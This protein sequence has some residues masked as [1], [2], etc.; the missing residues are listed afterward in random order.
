VRALARLCGVPGEIVD[1]VPSGNVFDGRSDEEMLGASYDEIE[2]FLRLREVH[3]ADLAAT[4]SCAAALARQHAHNQHKYRVGLPS[5]TV[6]V[7]PRGVPG[8]SSDEVWTPRHERRPPA[9]TLPGQWE[10][11]PAL[12]AALRTRDEMGLTGLT[13]SARSA[14]FAAFPASSPLSG[15]PAFAPLSEAAPPLPAVSRLDLGGPGLA[16][17][18]DDV[19]SAFA[20]T[21]LCEAMTRSG[22]AEPVSVTGLRDPASVAYGV[23][24]VRAT[25]WAPELAKFLGEKL[26]PAIPSVR[27]VERVGW[28]ALGLSPVLRF[29]RYEHGGHHLGHY[30]APF[31]YGDGRCTLMSVVFYLTHAEDSGATRFLRDGQDDVPPAARNYAD[32]PREALPEEVLLRVAPRPGRVLL[33]DHRLCHDVERWNGPGPRIIIRADVVYEAIPDGVP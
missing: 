18:A 5:V 14:Q 10:P 20:C 26:A 12:V 33:F 23:G 2:L 8:G 9:G 27:F 15:S 6:D 13:P 24:S 28:R 16:L 3:R 7:L 1:A 22:Q 19:L 21:A 11:D 17:V 31:D 4:L 32:W 29:M 30:D 25:A